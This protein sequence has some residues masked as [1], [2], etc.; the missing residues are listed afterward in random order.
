[1]SLSE[2]SLEADLV[3]RTVLDAAFSVRKGL[4]VGLVEKAYVRAL[5]AELRARGVEVATEVDVSL[6]VDG[7]RIVGGRADLVVER[8]VLVEVKATELPLPRH[9]AQALTYLRC[10]TCEIAFVLNF[11]V[12]PFRSGIQRLVLT[13][14]GGR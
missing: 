7:E 4:G 12:H 9:R 14:R 3:A 5:A 13:G 2:P 1:M 10:S 11:C 8:K 6:V